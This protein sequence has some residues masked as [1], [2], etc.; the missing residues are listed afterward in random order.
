MFERLGSLMM[1]PGRPPKYSGKIAD[2]I[3]TL[4]VEGQ[5]LREICGGE[6]F[7]NVSTVFRWLADDRYRD[8]RDQYARAKEVQAEL[9]ADEILRIADD[10]TNDYVQ[11]QSGNSVRFAFRG[12]HVQRSKLR[13]DARKWLLSKMLPKKYGHKIEIKPH[14]DM[15]MRE[16]EAIYK[17]MIERTR[18]PS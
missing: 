18:R 11:R 12:E 15:T 4:I 17:Q 5:T 8:F 10:G 3:C 1:R 16:A 14:D 6:E 13:I 9:M 7:P 2:K